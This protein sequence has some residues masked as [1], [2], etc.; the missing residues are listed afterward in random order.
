MQLVNHVLFLE[1][2]ALHWFTYA[3]LYKTLNHQF[4]ESWKD[5][6]FHCTSTRKHTQGV[7]YTVTKVRSRLHL[8]FFLL[9]HSLISKTKP[10]QPAE[11]YYKSSHVHHNKTQIFLYNADQVVSAK[12]WVLQDLLHS[13]KEADTFWTNPLKNKH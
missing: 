4:T 1:W 7:W 5:R 8:W 11:N 10:Q 3:G 2:N 12:L 13:N 6:K 9:L